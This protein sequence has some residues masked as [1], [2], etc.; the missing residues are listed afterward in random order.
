MVAIVVK[1]WQLARLDRAAYAKALRTPHE[2]CVPFWTLYQ[3]WLKRY[4]ER[5]NLAHR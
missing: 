4:K 1:D 5:G 2:M 3:K